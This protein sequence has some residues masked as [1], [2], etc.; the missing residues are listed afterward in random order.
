MTKTVICALCVLSLVSTMPSYNYAWGIGCQA[1]DIVTADDAAS[2][3]SRSKPTTT[4]PSEK[5]WSWVRRGF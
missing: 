2:F 1:A 3:L 4:D 5:Q